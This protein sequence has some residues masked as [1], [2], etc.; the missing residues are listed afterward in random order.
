MPV[1]LESMPRHNES[2]EEESQIVQ[3]ITEATTHI[4][5]PITTHFGNLMSLFWTA[6]YLGMPSKMYD[7]IC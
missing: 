2:L 7:L 3:H 1:A 4:C 6:P 5:S